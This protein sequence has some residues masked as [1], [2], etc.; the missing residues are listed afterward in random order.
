MVFI[1][2]QVLQAQFLLKTEFCKHVF[3]EKLNFGGS[4]FL[5]N[6]VSEI[7]FQEQNVF[8]NIGSLLKPNFGKSVLV[9]VERMDQF[10]KKFST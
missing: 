1:K 2:N 7:R 5:L 10:G 6:R 3:S 4:L 9:D 8:P